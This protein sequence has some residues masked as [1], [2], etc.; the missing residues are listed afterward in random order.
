MAEGFN[1]Y[2]SGHSLVEIGK[3]KND[4]KYI[5]DGGMQKKSFSVQGRAIHIKFTLP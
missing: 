5:F 4:I 3:T 2:P 1:A